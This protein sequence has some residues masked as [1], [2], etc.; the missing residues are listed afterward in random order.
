MSLRTP[1]LAASGLLSA[2]LLSGCMT[3][4]PPARFAYFRVPCD[5]PGAVVVTPIALEPGTASGNAPGAAPVSDQAAVAPQGGAAATCV[6]AVADARSGYRGGYYPAA[7]YYGQ[8]Y[9]GSL[10]IGFGFGS[11]GGHRPLG[12]H[13]GSGHSS[14]RH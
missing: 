3:T 11:H 7:G 13:H 4:P 2:T 1:A 14:R 6:V 9:Y 8:P 10:G 5:T 12:G